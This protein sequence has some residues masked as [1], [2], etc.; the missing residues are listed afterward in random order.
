MW[1]TFVWSKTLKVM[2]MSM[3]F[4]HLMCVVL[5]LFVELCGIGT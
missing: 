5:R 4:Y 1:Q 3:P 2:L